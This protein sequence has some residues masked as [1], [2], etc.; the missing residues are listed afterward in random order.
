MNTKSRDLE[1]ENNR[2]MYDLL[3]EAVKP[4]PLP[5]VLGNCLDVLLKLSWLSL[6]PK[7][8][9]FI[10]EK[11]KSGGR[12]LRL[13]AE[14]NI[15]S[16]IKALCD[17]VPFGHCLCGRAAAT[18]CSIHAKCID[19][20]HET[21]FEGIQPHG[22]Y[23]V[24]ILLKGEVLGVIVLYLP[25]GTSRYDEGL[26]FLERVAEALA[27]VI[28]LNQK[29]DALAEKI[30]E[31]DYQKF[32]LDQ[33]A[34][35][36]VA[37]VAGR[38]RYVN[39]KF[40]EVS[41]YDR[42]E[43]VGQNHRIIRSDAHPKSFFDDLWRT[44]SSGKVWHGE[45]KNRK[46]DGSFYWVA[47]TIVPFVN[48]SGKPFQ[49]VAIRTDI[50]SEKENEAALA[51]ASF[52]AEEANR[53]KSDF[54][55]SMSHELR[56]PLNAILGFA[57]MI[58]QEM[59]GPLGTHTYADYAGH[60]RSSGQHLLQIIN[61]ILDLSKVEAGKLQISKAPVDIREVVEECAGSVSVNA[62]LGDRRV[63]IDI[64]DEIGTVAA[65]ARYFKQVMFN[66][67]SN[68]HKYCPA[69]KPIRVVA[70]PK[71]GGGV[72]VSVADDGIGIPKADLQRVLE[73]FG[74]SENDATIA[75]QGTG[76][77][78]PIARRLMELHGGSL[79]LASDVGKGT[80]ATLYFPA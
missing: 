33:H 31:L 67:L 79:T 8:G 55:A 1:A 48:A 46:K 23:N 22:H 28:T 9:I 70:K 77:G 76:L 62:A 53:A 72:L 2:V 52:E 16:K 63:T 51:A 15:G 3:G 34:I 57:E 78:L 19:H 41:G 42:D 66:L 39:D 58:E 64:P 7:G 65:D 40:C 80:T 54:L 20:R 49:Y 60:I 4:L 27:L 44:I 12:V 32:A 6:L 10:T 14:R 24:P 35:V 47:S 26:K 37:D 21:R 75:R 45:I 25:D 38:I 74:Q 17:T 13:I 59:L 36:S 73:P 18:R 61:D 50:T 68:A 43:L 69:D 56:T 71:A 29:S 5:V 30:I 11:D